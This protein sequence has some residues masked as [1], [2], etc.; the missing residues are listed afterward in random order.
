MVVGFSGGKI[1]ILGIVGHGVP[2][3]AVAVFEV[4]MVCLTLS[5]VCRDTSS[6]A[7]CADA[8]FLILFFIA[9]SSYLSVSSHRRPVTD[10]KKQ[11]WDR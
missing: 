10:T 5:V 4:V 7:A 6:V 9:L 1:S 3:G 2:Q 8:I 11:D